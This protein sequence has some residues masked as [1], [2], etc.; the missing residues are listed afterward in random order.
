ML[1][2][3]LQ[4]LLNAVRRRLWRGLF[5]T[6]LRRALWG[7]AALLVLV[8]GLALLIGRVPV[9]VVLIAVSSLWV[10]LLVWAAGRRPAYSDCA[11]WA[12]RHLGGACAFTT[13]LELDPVG[14]A[15]PDAAAVR[16][17]QVWSTKKAPECLRALAEKQASLRLARPLLATMVCM[18][19]AAIVLNLS[20]SMPAPFRQAA[21]SLHADERATPGIGTSEGAELASE[22]AK[23]VRADDSRR[24]TE[25]REDGGFHDAANGKSV[26]GQRPAD[27]RAMAAP[28]GSKPVNASS[29][30]AAS[31][32]APAQPRKDEPAGT[33][34]A[35]GREAGG[36][37]D[38]AGAGI[39]RLPQG[40]MVTRGYEL[41]SRGRSAEMQA[42]M[43]REGSY[44]EAL[45]LTGQPPWVPTT[46][47]A[48]ATPPTATESSRLTP[49]ETSYVQAWMKAS[50][51][52]R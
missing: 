46:T 50:A 3:E 9:A 5:V 1:A 17:L 48:A 23:A 41:K 6:A 15:K 26:A 8:I 51:Q 37:I 32:Q 4:D 30:S 47:V 35:A 40:T 14:P 38:R 43:D 28:V 21:T 13:L 7:S 29:M 34:A 16:R 27:A 44:D 11:L 36:S 12:D 25:R 18:A 42:D 39:S 2:P 20:D 22:I 31:M 49:T 10:L 19:L 45:T 24:T 33:D 52:R